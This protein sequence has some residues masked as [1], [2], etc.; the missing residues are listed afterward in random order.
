MKITDENKFL[1]FIPVVALIF[2]FL[3]GYED[4][5]GFKIDTTFIVLLF[6]ATMPFLGAYFEDLKVGDFGITFRS[7]SYVKQL[8]AVVSGVAKKQQL[9]FYKPRNNENSI[10]EA[11]EV[12]VGDLLEHYQLGHIS[13]VISVGSY[14]WGQTRLIIVCYFDTI[15][16]FF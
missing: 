6:I 9:T 4:K 15:V 16:F 13:W 12:I 10:G 5:I 8:L 3:H 1:F 11:I 2:I 14:Q 7:P